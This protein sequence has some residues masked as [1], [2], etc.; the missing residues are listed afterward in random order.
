MKALVGLLYPFLLHPE[1][2]Q[3]VLASLN[4]VQPRLA[5][6]GLHRPHGE[7][8]T[9]QARVTAL[10]ESSRFFMIFNQIH[11]E[12]KQKMCRIEFHILHELLGENPYIRKPPEAGIS[13]ESE[14]NPSSAP[15][16]SPRW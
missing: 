4:P 1:L 5:R 9:N 13:L 2:A 11:S 7:Q 16:P 8:S 12:S 6:L 14:A 3:L 10:R 15:P